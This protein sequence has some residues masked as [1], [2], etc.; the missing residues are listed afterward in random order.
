MGYT[1]DFEG[2]FELN[3]PLE[4]NH[5]GYL[6]AFA[7][8]RRVKR[9][10]KIASTLEDPIRNSVS[11]PIGKDGSFF[12]GGKGFCGQDKDESIIDYNN[13]PSG[14]PALWCQWIPNELG[15]VIEWDGNEKF[16]CYVEWID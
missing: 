9:D 12:V 2:K 4:E 16:Y 7:G 10:E 11:L 1:T 8:T 13:P 14:Q 15:T 6:L 5:K 3:K